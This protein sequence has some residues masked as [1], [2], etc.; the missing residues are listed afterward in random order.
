[1]VFIHRLLHVYT[2]WNQINCYASVKFRNKLSADTIQNLYPTNLELVETHGR[3][4]NRFWRQSFLM[5]LKRD[6]SHIP[7]H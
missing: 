4:C 7:Q 3:A 6:I 1:M 5:M 2:I